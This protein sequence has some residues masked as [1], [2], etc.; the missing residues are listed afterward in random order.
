MRLLSLCLS[1]AVSVAAALPAL[2]HEF[3][4][5]PLQ[6]RIAPDQPLMADIRVGQQ[7]KGSAYSYI[8]QNI[9]RFD[10]VMGDT[11]IPVTGRAGDRPALNMPAPAEGL[12]TV[13]HQTTD[14]FLTWTDNAKF[15]G[16]VEHKDFPWVL[17]QHKARGLPDTGF[18][19]RYSRY[20]K[21]LIAVG[22]GAGEDR[23]VGMLTEIVALANPY[24]DDVSGGMPVL[25]LYEGKP[26]TDTQVE[27]FARAPGAEV[28]DSFYRTDAE[29]KVTIPVE[30]GVEYLFDAVVMRPLDAVADGDPVWESLW[31]SLTFEVPAE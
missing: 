20:G 12:V 19:E 23:E 6:Y 26:R 30:P 8:P 3:F 2:S 13:V 7:F 29:G 24:V 10:L 4:I 22:D 11:V 14:T 1:A 27:V 25:V 17:D 15:V 16:F 31:A 21:A 18:K 9:A 5:E 28:T